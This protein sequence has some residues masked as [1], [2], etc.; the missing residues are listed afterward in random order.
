MSVT[1]DGVER[2]ALLPGDTADESFVVPLN[3]PE[4]RIVDDEPRGIHSKIG[5]EGA[6]AA[7]V[8]VGASPVRR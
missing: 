7:L 8:A 3:L 4:A 6:A 1:D 2:E 5:D